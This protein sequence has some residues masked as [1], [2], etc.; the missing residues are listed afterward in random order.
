M[1]VVAQVL[2]ETER[3]GEAEGGDGDGDGGDNGGTLLGEVTFSALRFLPPP[4]PVAAADDGGDGG[5]AEE[6]F[7]LVLPGDASTNSRLH[8][9]F[10]F[11]TVKTGMASIRLGGVRGSSDAVAFAEAPPPTPSR[12]GEGGGTTLRRRRLR[13]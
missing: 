12:S 10:R 6:W 3:G 9:H 7:P 1:R 13:R 2:D 5:W 4:R 8:L 11:D